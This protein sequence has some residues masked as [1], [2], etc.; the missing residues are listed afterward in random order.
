[1][2]F[3]KIFTYLQIYL[4]LEVIWKN[5]NVLFYKNLRVFNIILLS[6]SIIISLQSSED[7]V[8]Q[9]EDK[10]CPSEISS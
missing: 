10:F 2:K 8:S 5:N 1:M 7:D 4:S 9:Q 3:Y 6:P